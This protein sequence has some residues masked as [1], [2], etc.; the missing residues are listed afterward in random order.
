MVEDTDIGAQIQSF[1]EASAKAAQRINSKRSVPITIDVQSALMRILN[2]E[3]PAELLARHLGDDSMVELLM[4]IDLEA[5]QAVEVVTLHESILPDGVAR[6]LDEQIVK[7]KGERWEIHKFD[8]DPFPSNP[9]AHNLDSGLKLHLGTGELFR[10]R[11]CV[12]RITVK[13]LLQL[14]EKVNAVALPP[15]EE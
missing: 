14:R 10:K 7:V 13:R 1:I 12:G 4:S 6:R 9:H 8:A 11:A 3:D 5:L 2:L 15:F